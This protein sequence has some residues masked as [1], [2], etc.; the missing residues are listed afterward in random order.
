M[1]RASEIVSERQALAKTYND[2]FSDFAGLK[3][4]QCEQGYEHGYQS[5]PCLFMPE[6]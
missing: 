6:K 4:P 2:A 1:D 5:Y 3:T